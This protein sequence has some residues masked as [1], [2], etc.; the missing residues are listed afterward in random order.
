MPPAAGVKRLKT[1]PT[2][3]ERGSPV[4]GEMEK[5]NRIAWKD[6]GKEKMPSSL[7]SSQTLVDVGNGIDHEDLRSVSSVPIMCT[8]RC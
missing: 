6:K 3:S 8:E 4:G 7:G 5:E 1:S 2:P